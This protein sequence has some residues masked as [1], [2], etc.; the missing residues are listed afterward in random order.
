MFNKQWLMTAANDPYWPLL[1]WPSKY[2]R[3]NGKI[4]TING[5][6]EKRNAAGIPDKI[7]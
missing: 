5:G 3:S 7:D 4:M 1:Q 6:E 2:R